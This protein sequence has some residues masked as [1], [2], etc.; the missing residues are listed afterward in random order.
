MYNDFLV[1]IE[2]NQKLDMKFID[3]IVDVNQNEDIDFKLDD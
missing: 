3:M 1:D 2:E